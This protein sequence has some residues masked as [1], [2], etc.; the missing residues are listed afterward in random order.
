MDGCPAKLSTDS[1][2]PRDYVP[3]GEVRIPQG[4]L[5]LSAPKSLYSRGTAAIGEKL[6]SSSN[7]AY[8]SD[9]ECSR[10]LGAASQSMSG[11]FTMKVKQSAEHKSCKMRT[12]FTR[13]DSKDN[14]LLGDENVFATLSVPTDD[15]VLVCAFYR[16]CLN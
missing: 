5:V 8:T 3:I 6:M 7:L 10:T 11:N 1:T 14:Q 15:S 13:Q 12:N 2:L 9:L 16:R 4:S